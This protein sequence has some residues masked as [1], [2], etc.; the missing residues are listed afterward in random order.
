MKYIEKSSEKSFGLLFSL[1]FF[2]SGL[3]F[4]FKDELFFLVFFLVSIL[5]FF[6]SF[7]SANLL[8]YPNKAWHKF[9]IL[10]GIFVS[11]LVM[12][13]IF[14]VTVIPIG[15]TMKLARKDLLRTEISHDQPSYWIDREKPNTNMTKQY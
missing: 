2:L 10:L 1:I 11:P 6:M 12:L 7:F 14:C 8:I 5:L 9:G 4:L 13:F 15:L 3:Y